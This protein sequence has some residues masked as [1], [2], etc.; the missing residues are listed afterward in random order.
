MSP[1]S[2]DGAQ[3]VAEENDTQHDYDGIRELDNPLP[4]W[5]LVTFYGAVVF[6]VGYWFYYHT[7]AVGE[8]PLAAYAAELAAGEKLQLAA[9]LQAIGEDQLVALSKTPD[10]VQRGA[11]VFKQN[12]VACHG[13]RGQ[14]IIGPNLTDSYW[15]HGSKAKQIHQVIATGVL[16][17]GMP[18]WRPVLGPGKV[19]D[20]TAFV[21][22]LKGTNA[23]GKAAQGLSDDGRT[24]P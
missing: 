5:W 11:A 9:E 15:L 12:C 14:G 21:L 7:L 1:T 6:S 24:A 18:S 16:D 23:P 22:S 4:R 20:A 3:G 2:T 19:Q 13:E 8:L 17:K 10:A